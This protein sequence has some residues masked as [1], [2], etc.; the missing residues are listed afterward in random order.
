MRTSTLISL[1]PPTRVILFSCNARSTLAWA[2]IDM[3]PISSRNSV[4]PLACSNFPIRCL[5][6]EVKA[7]F[8]W[9]NNSLSI[10]SAGMAAQFTSTNWPLERGLCSWIQRATNSFP[11]PFS[12]VIKTRASVGATLAIVCLIDS[13]AELSPT[14]SLVL[15]TFRLSTLVS[16]I[17]VDLSSA[18]RTVIR[19]RFKS[20]G[21]DK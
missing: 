7:P 15:D 3:S 10:S 17:K 14:I 6:A 19:R 11:V 2:D 4:P 12:P 8:S 5:I 1:S 18:L 20:G 21:L 9:P 16:V 13:M